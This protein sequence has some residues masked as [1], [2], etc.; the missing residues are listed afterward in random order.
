MEI[1]GDLLRAPFQ[2]VAD[3]CV[4][5]DILFIVF[6]NKAKQKRLIYIKY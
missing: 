6:L 3:V 4:T 5:H 2:Y 1:Q